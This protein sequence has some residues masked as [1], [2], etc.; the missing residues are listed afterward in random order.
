MN[1][2]IVFAQAVGP[3]NQAELIYIWNQAT[4][5]GKAIIL[6]LV[7]FSIM[8]WSV[9]ITKALQMRR[10]RKLNQYFTAE[11]ST[12]KHV[13][14][15]FDRR[16]QAEGCPFFVVYQAGSVEL[17]ARLKADAGEGRKSQVSLKSLEH[18]KRRLEN[19]VAQ[20]SLKLESGLIL[21][22]IA[23]SG[24]PFLGLLG[25]V[26][27]VMST[28]GHVAQQGSATLSTMAPGVAA[29][30]STTVAGLLVAIPS[31]FGY[32]WLVHTLRTLTVGLDNFAQELVSKMETEYLSDE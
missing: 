23:V 3:S 11:F 22:A 15:M 14:D 13:L 30:L 31:M 20:E 2:P 29:A 21:L 1:A 16:I 10:A 19:A 7:I 17:D 27:G 4:S 12:Q 25:T 5:E 24:A 32:N 8:A 26:W 18:V 9:M 28:F 6:C